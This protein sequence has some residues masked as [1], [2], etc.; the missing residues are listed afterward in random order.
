MSLRQ[1]AGLAGE[2]VST[3]GSERRFNPLLAPPREAFVDAVLAA[4][5]PAPGGAAA[6]LSS[7]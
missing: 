2:P 5:P 4:L 1:R 6:F 7:N 3:F